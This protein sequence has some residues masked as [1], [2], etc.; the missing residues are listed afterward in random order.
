MSFLYLKHFDLEKS[1]FQI[2]PDIDFF[3]SGSQRGGIL[4]A[5]LH[6]ACHEEGI[7][8]AVAEVGS[9]KTLLARLM[10]SRLPEDISSVYLANPCFSRDE[11]I[12]AISRDLGL[13]SQP[14]STEENLAQLH[15]ELLRRHALGLRVL[16]V[17]DE[18]HAMPPESLEEVRLLSNLETDRH[19]LVNIMLFG[20]P[21]LDT[22]LAERRLR[23]LRDR[24]IHRFDLPPLPRDEATAYIDHR[25]RIAGW[26]GGRLFTSAAIS[27]LLKASQG[28]ARRINLLADKALLAAY[29]EGVKQVEKR[30]VKTACG[31]L[32]ADPATNRWAG[33]PWLRTLAISLALAVPMAGSAVWA[34][35]WHRTSAPALLEPV[36]ARGARVAEATVVP[37][38]AKAPA[39]KSSAGAMPVAA[40]VIAK[41]AAPSAAAREA[42]KTGTAKFDSQRLG[43][44]VKRT[45]ELLGDQQSRGFTLQ[46]ASL[47]STGNVAEYLGEVS[48]LVDASR[49]YAHHRV[50]NGKSVVAVYL[51]RYS[52]EQEARDALHS[53]PE[54]LKMNQPI[55]RTWARIRQEPNP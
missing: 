26:R 46:L 22:L 27:L 6:V 45:E 10:I 52:T 1:P 14:A 9:G 25:L 42:E 35:G 47:S 36:A 18:A 51:G 3:F 53:L 5:L 37:V 40:S 8:T 30:H 43:A 38:A 31:E 23:Q 4:T 34:L 28:R 21:E 44:L 48:Q 12:S 13:T 29:A 16:L 19:K 49:I 7:V 20:Q 24:V 11:I 54:P 41:P 50:Y 33:L 2:T 15:Q 39:I 17:I 55:L 32:H